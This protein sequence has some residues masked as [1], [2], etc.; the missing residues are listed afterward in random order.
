MDTSPILKELEGLGATFCG[1][2]NPHFGK[3]T[4]NSTFRLPCT[5]VTMQA[6]MEAIGNLHFKQ[7]SS[8]LIDVHP[9]FVLSD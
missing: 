9:N 8:A 5:F 2:D 6:A 3:V 1:V 7:I 4:K